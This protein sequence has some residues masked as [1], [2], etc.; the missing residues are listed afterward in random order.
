MGGG[1][2][3]HEFEPTSTLAD[4]QNFLDSQTQTTCVG[5]YAL[6]TSFPRHVFTAA[7]LHQTLQQLGTYSIHHGST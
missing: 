7:E 2:L 6:M 1:T 3:V 4:V 5:G